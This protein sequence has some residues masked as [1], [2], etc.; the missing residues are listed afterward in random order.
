MSISNLLTSDIGSIS[1]PCTVSGGLTGTSS[2]NFKRLDNIVFCSLGGVTGTG[3]TSSFVITPNT[4][5]PSQ[6][7]PVNSPQIVQ[8]IEVQS[9][10]LTVPALVSAPQALTAF[11]ITLQTGSFSGASGLNSEAMIMWRVNSL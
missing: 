2:I 5:V 11:T 8:I 1:I 4:A 7:L 6:F 10:S 3:S 9:A